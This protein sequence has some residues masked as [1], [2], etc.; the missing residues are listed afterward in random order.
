MDSEYF[1]GDGTPI[2]QLI[3]MDSSPS[4]TASDLDITLAS[5]TDFQKA[6][7]CWDQNDTEDPPIGRF[8][9]DLLTFIKKYKEIS[10]RLK[11]WERRVMIRKPPLENISYSPT[12]EKDKIVCIWETIE[13]AVKACEILSE[14]Y[15]ALKYHVSDSD[16]KEDMDLLGLLSQSFIH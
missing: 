10:M 15:T 6:M 13:K 2:S 8:E 7:E 1:T 14:R 4:T 11:H 16:L 12:N 3:R 9:D 5:E